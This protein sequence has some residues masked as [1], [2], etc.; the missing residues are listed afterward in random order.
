[1]NKKI[2]ILLAVIPLIIIILY[3]SGN[4]FGFGMIMPQASEKEKEYKEKFEEKYDDLYFSYSPPEGENKTTYQQIWINGKGSSKNNRSELENKKLADEVFNSFIK[5]YSYK[6]LVD[7]F[8]IEIENS[9]TVYY[10]KV[11]K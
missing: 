1:M 7:S 6:E 9:K 5:V 4:V 8:K 2:K 10:Y 3:I 11:E